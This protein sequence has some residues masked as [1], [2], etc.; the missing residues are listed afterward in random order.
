MSSILGS[1]DRVRAGAVAVGSEL[2][3]PQAEGFLGG[4]L[5]L[6]HRYYLSTSLE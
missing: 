5:P 6:P 1:P 3:H 4:D 2:A